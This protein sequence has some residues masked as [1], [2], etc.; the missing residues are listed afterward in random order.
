VRHSVGAD[1]TSW[2]TRH[3]RVTFVGVGRPQPSPVPQFTRARPRDCLRDVE[4][5]CLTSSLNELNLQKLAEWLAGRYEPL[6][7]VDRLREIFLDEPLTGEEARVP[8]EIGWILGLAS[9][10][11]FLVWVLL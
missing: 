7:D 3:A 11:F 2:F 5:A 10:G 9:L 4:G 1:A 6:R 8:H